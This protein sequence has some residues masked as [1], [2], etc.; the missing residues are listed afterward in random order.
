MSILGVGLSAFVGKPY[1]SLT[2]SPVPAVPLPV[3]SAIP[4]IGPAFFDQQIP[5]YASWAFFA[6]IAGFLYRSR[7]GLVLRAIGEAPASAFATGLPVI[8]V[9]YAATLFGGAM[10]G[11]AG[12]FLSVCYTPVW[13]EGMVAG[14]GWIAL[15]LVVFATWRPAR[16]LLGA[17]LFGGVMIAQLFVQGSGA[18]VEVP[19][20]FLSALPY[21]ATIVV[22]VAIS[23]NPNAIRLNAP[24]ALGQPYR[25]EA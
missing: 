25:P 6:A 2:L 8:G 23:R 20:Q 18:S 3:L 5:V 24:A 1:E 9:R 17:Y 14:R 12:A 16:V 15:A 4:V 19:S 10:A 22:L 21:L 13:V 11:L 7:A